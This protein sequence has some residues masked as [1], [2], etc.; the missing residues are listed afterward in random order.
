MPFAFAGVY[1]EWENSSTQQTMH[2]F[3][4]VTTAAPPGVLQ[5]IGHPRCPLILSK[6]QEELWL[7]PHAHLAD[8]T[9]I[10][11]P[12]VDLELNAYPVSTDIK[13]IQAE[14]SDLLKPT[15]DALLPE[16]SFI[17]HQH[18]ELFGMGESRAKKR[19]ANEGP[20]L[21]D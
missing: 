18:I 2:S 4:I 8:I 9:S 3:A 13:S 5:Q 7:D 19:R 15:G 1:D 14:G 16:T 10:L 12:V 6:Q 20:T 17:L 11:Q 21:F